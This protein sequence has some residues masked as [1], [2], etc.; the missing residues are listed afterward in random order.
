MSDPF[1]QGVPEFPRRVGVGTD[2][3]VRTVGVGVLHD[4]ACNRD[5]GRGMPSPLQYPATS[6]P[7][8]GTSFRDGSNAADDPIAV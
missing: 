2:P 1:V 7:H 3:Y 6:A 8:F 5:Y 4:R